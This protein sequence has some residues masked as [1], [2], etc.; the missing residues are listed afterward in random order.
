MIRSLFITTLF[1][2]FFVKAAQAQDDFYDP[3]KV[4]E[5][6]IRFSQPDWSR[7]L[8]SLFINYGD[9]GRLKGDVTVNGKVLK[10]VGVRYKGFSSWN[11]EEI[12]NPFNIDL[13]YTVTN[14]NYQGHTKIKLSNVIHDPSFVRE[15]LAY[16]IAR[17]YMPAS[18]ANYAM[19]YV[20]DSLIGLY[21]NVEAVD[22]QFV[23]THYGSS[24]GSFFKGEP[25]KLV[26]PF[27][28]NANLGYTHGTDTAGYMPFYKNV[29]DY[30]WSE[31]LNFI[32]VL[33][34]NS[35]SI[36]TVLNIDRALWMHAFNYSLLNL[37]SYIGYSQNY[38]LYADQSGRFNPIPWDL[39]M[40]FGSFRD[41][42]GSNN[43]LGVTIPKVKLLDPL[44]H[45]FFSVSPRPLMTKLFSN[46]V[47]RRMYLAHIR[48]IVNENFQDNVCYNRALQLQDQIGSYVQL[49]GNKFYTYQDFRNNVDSTVGGSAGITLYPG[50]R[51]LVNA[52]TEYLS[53]Y[54]GFKGEPLIS[55]ISH[56]PDIP[57]QGESF[58]V[59]AK[60]IS[61]SRVTLA[62]RYNHN[63][64]FSKINMYDDGLSNDG[65]A[66]DGIYGAAVSAAGA[67][68]QYYFYAENDSAG[69]FSPARA[70]YEFYTIQCDLR[71]GDLVINE[72]QNGGET[73]SGYWIEL[74][75]TGTE[76]IQLNG[77]S[78]LTG[79][80]NMSTM[81]FP[82]TLIEGGKFMLIAADGSAGQ[83]AG[84]TLPSTSG[85]AIMLLNSTGKTIDSL[86][87]SL[88][89][90]GKSLGRYPNGY[91]PFV[92]M[93][94]SPGR[95]NYV[96]ST[97]AK[98]FSIYPN[99]ASDIATL[100]FT[101]PM[102]P[103]TI[104]LY[105]MA[106]QC[107]YTRYYQADAE[108]INSIAVPIDVTGLQGLYLAKFSSNGSILTKKLIVY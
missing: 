79:T 70:E 29:S 100:E 23:K 84:F 95:N 30:G 98:G 83:Y 96:G 39:N 19:L 92:Y 32:R 86:T 61:A 22:Q 38:Y 75:N 88:P 15:V 87:L 91:G 55:A 107:M 67:V 46:D 101:N 20:N 2:A 47:W 4:Q 26:Y 13:D 33:N 93:E 103:Y 17:Q 90:A 1:V 52:R 104:E 74:L 65:I 49:D 60:V 37:D 63:E 50:I 59:S 41:S 85:T 94:A 57:V 108:T 99:P 35:D 68:M 18:R 3:G 45:L 12:K 66:G 7:V 25:E 105:N 8:D 5:I 34:T 28:Q 58:W 102:H 11:E 48:T 106:G 36:S 89:V 77:F 78:L 43:F 27:G 10:N 40:S 31:L 64:A 16:E 71:P 42:D 9:Q 54:P 44:Q 97:P 56:Q 80:G 51:D 14:Q 81:N 53:Q 24:T 6:R 62:Y 69:A 73:N 21:T 76:P 82:N 72:V